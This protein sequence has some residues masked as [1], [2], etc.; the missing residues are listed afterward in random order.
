[1]AD[2]KARTIRL[3]RDQGLQV[4]NTEHWNPYSK[5]KQDFGG[6]ADCVSWDGQETVAHQV[7]STHNL[8]SHRTKI[9]ESMP[10]C[11]WA[12]TPGNRLLLWGWK[13]VK[14]RWTVAKVEEFR[15]EDFPSRLRTHARLARS[16]FDYLL[17]VS[18][19]RRP[20]PAH[21]GRA[22]AC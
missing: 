14:G 13:K 21:N 15:H 7:T 5:R 18:R 20:E 1:M 19:P 22:R 2:L 9:L 3:L 11:L 4:E 8:A 12:T 16:G 17:P 10:A 6:F